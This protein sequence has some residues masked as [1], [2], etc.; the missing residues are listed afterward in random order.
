MD[1]YSNCCI[2]YHDS[3]KAEMQTEVKM[4]TLQKKQL[5]MENPT[6]DA[7]AAA[8]QKKNAKQK[9]SAL[10]EMKR[11]GKARELHPALW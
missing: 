7:R 11:A 10:K 1:Y 2:I 4:K 6:D 5:G 8:M 9:T 3:L